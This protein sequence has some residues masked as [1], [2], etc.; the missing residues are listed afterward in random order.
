MSDVYQDLFGE[1][2]YTGKGLY[3]VD[4]F[5]AALAG[6]VPE[7]AI[8]SHDLFEGI[9]ARC[10]LISDIE[11]F[12]DFSVAFRSGSVANSSM[13]S[14]RLAIIAVDNRAEKVDR[15][16]HWAAQKNGRQFA[17]LIVRTGQPVSLAGQSDDVACVLYGLAWIRFCCLLLSRY[18]CRYT[19]HSYPV[20]LGY[21]N[22]IMFGF[23]PQI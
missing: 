15:C 4:A 19:M 11:L 7:N 22:P 12:E 17:T 18:C 2:N 21:R 16:R 20:I 5:E 9:Y 13:D 1:G 6:R 3:D 8:L 14:G 23:S 10:G